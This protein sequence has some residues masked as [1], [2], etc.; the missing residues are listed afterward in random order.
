MS[1]AF[2]NRRDQRPRPAETGGIAVDA[3]TRRL[4]AADTEPR[5]GR[6][7]RTWEALAAAKGRY[8][9]RSE[10]DPAALG[11]KL[12]PSVFLVDVLDRPGDAVPRFRFR[13]LGQ[14]ILDRESTRAGD[15]LDALGAAAEIAKIERH[16]LDCIDGKVSVRAAS[17]VWSDVHKEYLRYG[18]MMLPLSDDGRSVTHLIGLAL[19]EF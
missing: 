19:Y 17:L 11:A 12:L 2:S 6:F 5:W 7:L 9:S 15:Y 1:R 13:L 18:V 10:V 3:D 4:I 14:A 16:Y 8:P